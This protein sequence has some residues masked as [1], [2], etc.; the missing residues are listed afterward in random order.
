MT[1]V[2]ENLNVLDEFKTTS[3]KNQFTL[4]FLVES[5]HAVFGDR[6]RHHFKILKAILGSAIE[7]FL[8]FYCKIIAI[9]YMILTR[10]ISHA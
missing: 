1:A 7:V 9:S 8:S 2:M 4:I 3:V 6:V 10:I 5:S